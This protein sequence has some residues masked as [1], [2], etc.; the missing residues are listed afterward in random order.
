MVQELLGHSRLSTTQRYTHVGSDRSCAPT[1]PPIRERGRRGGSPRAVLME[2]AHATTVFCVRHRGEVA[3]AGDGQVTIGHTVPGRAQ[4]PHALPRSRR[5]RLCGSGR[6]RL[7]PLPALRGQARGIPGQHLPGRGGAGQGLA[8]RPGAPPPGGD[9]RGRRSRAHLHH[10]G[11]GD[12]I[13]PDDGLIGIGSGGP[14]AL[15]AARAL[16]AHS[17]LDARAIVR[18]PCASPPASAS[19]RAIRSPSKRYD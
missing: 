2:F 10:L 7:H 5:G 15:S 13:E 19:I 12:L 14:F 1:T 3:I 4:D 9:S 11:H 6:R 8:G 18:K 17:D 16:V